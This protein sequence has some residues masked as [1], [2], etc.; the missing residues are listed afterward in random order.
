MLSANCTQNQ[1]IQMTTLETLQVEDNQ[2]SFNIEIGLDNFKETILAGANVPLTDLILLDKDLLLE[3]LN[4]IQANLPTDFATAIEIANHKQQIISE[5]EA[6]ARL[7][8]RSAEEKASQILQESAIVRQAELDGAK[9][10]IKTERE[11]QELRK[12]AIAESEAIQKEADCYA[13]EVLKEI[14]QKLQKTLAIIQN[15]RQQLQ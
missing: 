3:Q 10:R 1:T 8:I 9:I 2:L 7:V 5:A 6:Y 4:Q 12:D 13:D 15:G 11:C 14:E